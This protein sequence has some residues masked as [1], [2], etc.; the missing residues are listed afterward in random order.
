MPRRTIDLDQVRVVQAD[1]YKGNSRVYLEILDQRVLYSDPW[2]LARHPA[3]QHDVTA[4]T[5]GE[6]PFARTDHEVD[7]GAVADMFRQRLGR[8]LTR[9]LLEDDPSLAEAWSTDTDR[10][11]DYVKPRLAEDLDR[12]A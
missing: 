3:F 1:N 11:I 10:D 12:E 9:L 4:R 7:T 8:I 6:E 2:A 5:F